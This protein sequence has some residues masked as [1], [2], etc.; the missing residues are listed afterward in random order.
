[1]NKKG[2]FGDLLA[3]N[4]IYLVI[5]VI[6]VSALMI[7]IGMN[8][9]GAGVWEDFYAKEIS[10]KIVN[11]AQVGDEV[12]LNVQKASEIALKN[13]VNKDAMFTFDN[14]NKEVCVK[15]RLAGSTCFAYF[16]NIQVEKCEFKL[17][18]AEGAGNTITFNL[19][20]S[21]KA[22]EKVK[23]KLAR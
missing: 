21:N 11:F 17:G 16:K 13:G 1:M 5:A 15:L 20:N 12:I 22:E 10:G 9:N 7:Y 8:A 2:D 6:A 14:K 19:Y 23:C 18:L 4:L 3:K